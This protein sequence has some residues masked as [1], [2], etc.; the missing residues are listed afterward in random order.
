MKTTLPAA[1]IILLAG[2]PAL[3][4]RLDE[5]LQGALIGIEKGR[6]QAQITLTP[7]VAVLPL[8]LAEI[9]ADGDG[10]IS[11]TEG[12]AYAE[13]VLRDLSITSDGRRVT[14]RLVSVQFPAI[15]QMKEGTGE[16]QLDFDA[17]LPRGGR[18]RTL[19]FE[20]HHQS[21]IAAYQVNCLVPRDPQ[22]RVVS[23]KRDYL[24]SHYE[25]AYVDGGGRS[26]ALSFASWSG[27]V[28]L[29]LLARFALVRRGARAEIKQ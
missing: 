7:G 23:Q 26:D 19:I 22:I 15:D 24:Q 28:A 1:A 21:R 12:R 25:L 11:K 8:V 9:D 16:I 10:A 3:A 4:H 20:N 5:Y 14:P 27:A 13:R 18:S 6:V 17:D 2:M 29:F